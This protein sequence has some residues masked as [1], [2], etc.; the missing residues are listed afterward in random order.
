MQRARIYKHF[1]EEALESDY[2]VG[3][4]WFQ[5]VDQVFTGR[6]DGENYQIGFVDICDRPH[7][8]MIEASREIR[9][10]MYHL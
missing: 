1:V 6:S 4:H 9:D 10:E 2:I 7:P 3:T 5:Y 8:E